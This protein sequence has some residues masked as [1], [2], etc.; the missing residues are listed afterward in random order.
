MSQASERIVLHY[1][2][3]LARAGEEPCDDGE[4]LHRFVAHGDQGAFAELVD[5]HGR[6][7]WGVCRHVLGHEQDA[8]DA[9]QATFLVLARRAASIRTSEAVGSWLYR[10]A[11]RVATKAGKDMARRRDMERR[12]GAARREAARPEFAWREMQAILQEELEALPE[13]YRAPFVLCCLEGRSGADAARLLGWKEGTVRGRLTR[14]R[15]QLRERLE[16]RGVLL[17]AVLLALEVTRESA[18]AVVPRALANTAVRVAVAGVAGASGAAS[19]RVTALAREVTRTMILSKTKIATAIVL[20][21]SL[22]AGLGITAA[23]QASAEPA[24]A[25][26]AVSAADKDRPAAEPSG[27]AKAAAPS[28]AAMAVPITGQVLTADG[29]PAAG[30][31]VSVC[32]PAPPWFAL[33]AYRAAKEPLHK[34]ADDKGRFTIA[35]PRGE[36]DMGVQVVATADG[37]GLDW[38]DVSAENADKPVTLRLCPDDVPIDG[39]ILDL[40]RRPVVGAVVEVSS[41][42]RAADGSDLKAWLADR[43]AEARYKKSRLTSL[44]V[45]SLSPPAAGVAGFAVSATTDKAG[46][47]RLAGLG[48]ETVAHLRVP[49]EGV[50]SRFFDVCTRN[51]KAAS[52][53]SDIK[54]DLLGIRTYPASFELLLGPGKVIIGTV[55]EKGTGKPVAGVVVMVANDGTEGRT[56][57]KGRYRITGVGKRDRHMIGAYGPHHFFAMRQNVPDSQGTEPIAVDFELQ[58][59]REIQGRLIDK[60]GRPVRGFV[61]Y[62]AQPDNSHLKDLDAPSY[63]LGMATGRMTLTDGTFR[64]LAIPGPGYLAVKAQQDRYTCAEF[65]EW[66]EGDE[67]PG[68]FILGWKGDLVAATPQNLVPSYC[69]GIVAVEPSPDDAK[70]WARDIVLDPG[71]TV[72]GTLVGPDG[73]P[74]AGAVAFGLT[75]LLTTTSASVNWPDRISRLEGADFTALGLNVRE[76]RP[77]FFVHPEKNL[78][79]L[80]VLRGDEKGPLEVRLEPLGT[81]T[82]RLL[83]SKGQPAAGRFITPLIDVHGMARKDRKDLPGNLMVFAGNELR[84]PVFFAEQLGPYPGC[85]ALLVIQVHLPTVQRLAPLL[86]LRTGP[87]P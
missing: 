50:E 10:V 56:D 45:K 81:A 6:L 42:K 16:R 22:F 29:K 21:A 34:V 37:A 71:K 38:V 54:G 23:R 47:F 39:R 32:A 24:P 70:S 35:V 65:K 85:P 53:A 51:D 84:S 36:R 41:L 68:D 67:S 77:V 43:A 44:P 52:I 33:A 75:A 60:D 83:D 73:K 48:R 20:G 72:K 7:V 18:S 82:D 26:P 5:R 49:C 19:A 76:P 58:P 30:A 31:K 63:V 13:K 57:A 9:F 69:H 15:Q 1:V 28:G 61:W 25:T 40:E 8:E 2:R 66:K 78:G 79:K 80:M 62:S 86:K 17:P 4:L 64:V 27:V 46:R 12:A 3:R 11:H 14:A 74:V 59:G 55:T 87:A